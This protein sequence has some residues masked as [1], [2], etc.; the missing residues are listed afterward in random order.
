MELEGSWWKGQLASD[1]HQ[2]LRYKELKL[3]SYKS[4][5][6]QL[7]LRRYFADLIAIVSN[8][9]KLCPT[10]RH[11]AVYL[12]DLFM[13][14]YDISI[15]QLH[16]V[17]LSCLLL[18]SKFEDKED[19]VPKL[20]QLNSLGCMT[21]MNLVLTKQNLLHMELLLLETFDWN[22][23]LPTPAHFIDYFL[24]I[25]VH[26]TDLHDGWPMICLEKTKIYMAK[27]ADYFLEV[28]LQDHVFLNYL[29]SLVAAACVA[30]SRIIL[31]LTPSWPTRLHRLTVYAWDILVPCIE[32][33]LIAHDNDVKEANKHK[34]QLSHSAT[35][36]IFPPL[37]PAT[38]QAHV[39]QHLPQF[40][41]SQHQL[42]FHHSAPQQSSC[43]QLVAAAHTSSFSLQTCT[44]SLT[45]S[46]QPR[47]HIQTAASVSLAAVP[48]E[49]KPCLGVSYNR[50]FP[51]NGHYSCI[52]Q[53]F[54][55]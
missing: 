55:R 5:S 29:P 46:V 28:S 15:Q 27:Y 41:Q 45:T 52:T 47:G 16:V 24:S 54:E 23:C 25:A 33:L 40:L 4:Q 44:S 39:Q 30:A 1:I 51:M 37:S 48:I 9:F 12:L 49:V 26:D 32:R 36:C 2:A 11:L 22:L 34:S 18:A 53:C 3:P 43:Q 19:R 38:P 31:R 8:R 17:A 35:P 6:P 21:N 10:A 50:S 7:N 14:R 20:D 13:D 42:Q